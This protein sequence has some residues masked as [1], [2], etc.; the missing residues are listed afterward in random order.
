MFYLLTFLGFA[1][2]VTLVV[3][4]PELKELLAA[5]SGVLRSISTTLLSFKLLLEYRH[6]LTSPPAPESK[7]GD[8]KDKTDDDIP[9]GFKGHYKYFRD[10]KTGRQILMP[11]DEAEYMEKEQAAEKDDDEWADQWVDGMEYSGARKN[12]NGNAKA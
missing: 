8:A 9:E 11:K 4:G 5:T 1:W 6:G 3:L 10:P 7:S 2:V 12:D